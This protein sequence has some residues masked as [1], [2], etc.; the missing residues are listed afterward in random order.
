MKK[1]TICKLK[2]DL[3]EFYKDR[4][5][6]DGLNTKCKTCAKIGTEK[7]TYLKLF[8]GITK[9]DY[10]NILRKQDNKCALCP[11][12]QL[13][14]RKR[15]SVDHDHG[16]GRVRG[17]LCTSCNFAIGLLG[18]NEESISKVLAYLRG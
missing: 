12:T 13:P 9:E 11:K 18:D 17:I 4:S 1:C 10:E 6:S 2:K 5:R 14:G 7:R 3:L 8:Y 16:T 15:L